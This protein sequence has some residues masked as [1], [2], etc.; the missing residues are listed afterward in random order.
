MPTP[1]AIAANVR[2]EMARRRLRAVTVAAELGMSQ[3]AMSR[4]LSGEVPFTAIEVY[5]LA[6]ILDVPI[7]SLFAT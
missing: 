4:R 6:Q 3:P 7:E 2:A 1:E 5:R